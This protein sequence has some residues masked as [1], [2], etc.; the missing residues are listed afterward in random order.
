MRGR[1]FL[2]CYVIPSNPNKINSTHANKELMASSEESSTLLA[3]SIFGFGFL[4]IKSPT[5]P[6]AESGGMTAPRSPVRSRAATGGAGVS[7]SMNSSSGHILSQA[8]SRELGS[9][10]KKELRGGKGDLV[11]P[12]KN[13]GEILFVQ[14]NSILLIVEPDAEHRKS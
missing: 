4:G 1:K 7:G 8:S 13:I 2:D 6:A 5:N 3:A 12:E 11:K 9:A 10:S 14:S